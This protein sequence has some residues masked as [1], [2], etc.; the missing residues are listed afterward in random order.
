MT[1]YLLKK[2]EPYWTYFG[3]K[4]WPV[5]A[6]VRIE[7]FYSFSIIRHFLPNHGRILPVLTFNGQRPLYVNADMIWQEMSNYRKTRMFVGIVVFAGSVNVFWNVLSKNLQIFDFIRKYRT[8]DRRWRVFSAKVWE[9]HISN[10]CPKNEGKI[11][12]VIFLCL[13]DT[14]GPAYNEFGY[15]GHPAITSI[16]PLRKITFD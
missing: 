13:S 3:A 9:D 16:F 14:L 1:F 15:N 5:S 2:F 7:F 8:I 11:S 10:V 6:N 4:R 12:L